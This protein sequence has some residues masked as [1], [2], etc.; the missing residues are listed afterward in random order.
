MRKSKV[1]VTVARTP[2]HSNEER[3]LFLVEA[4]RKSCPEKSGRLFLWRFT[5]IN[6]NL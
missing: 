4:I 5:I 6:G 3:L 2:F 1:K